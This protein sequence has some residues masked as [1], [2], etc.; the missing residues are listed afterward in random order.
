MNDYAQLY[1]KRYKQTKAS[2]KLKQIRKLL[3]SG[4]PPEIM[5]ALIVAVV[6][7]ADVLSLLK[8]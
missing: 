3:F 5:I 8:R 1:D 2:S 7:P 6:L 4:L